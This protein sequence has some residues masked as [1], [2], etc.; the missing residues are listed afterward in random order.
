MGTAMYLRVVP[1]WQ[2]M[3]KFEPRMSTRGQEPGRLTS[4]V[5]ATL[6]PSKTWYCPTPPQ[7]WLTTQYRW[8]DE[9]KAMSQVRMSEL[10]LMTLLV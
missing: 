5:M 9:S 7:D 6:A 10:V 4:G 3:R 1:T 8:V 2:V